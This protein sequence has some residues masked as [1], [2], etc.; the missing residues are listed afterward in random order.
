[1]PKNNAKGKRQ[2]AKAA[3]AQTDDDF[4]DMLAEMCAADLAITAATSV[5]NLTSAAANTT[6]SSS[7]SSFTPRVPGTSTPGLVAPATGQRAS[8][9]AIIAACKHND[10][11]QLRLW[12]RQGVRLT[13]ATP[14]MNC[15]VNGA[16]VGLV[17]C[18]IDD[19][20]AD[21]NQRN[22]DGVTALWLA[23]AAGKLDV[24]RELLKLHDVV[25]TLTR[26]HP[27]A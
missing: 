6:T 16:S 20:G 14:L 27:P 24:V 9:E 2:G 25:R 22:S 13:N 1:M 15:A 8:A 19:L 17:R 23:A 18:L 11:A 4:D 3:P 5:R 21:V 10:I 7:S 12:G 26:Q